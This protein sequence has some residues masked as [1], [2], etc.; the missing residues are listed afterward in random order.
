MIEG[1]IILLELIFFFFLL[2]SVKSNKPSDKKND[3]GIFSY[4]NK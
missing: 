3:L 1:F 4:K 2:S